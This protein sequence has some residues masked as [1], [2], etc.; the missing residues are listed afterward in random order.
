MSDYDLARHSNRLGAGNRGN[1]GLSGCDG[2]GS[3]AWRTDE[4]TTA[5]WKPPGVPPGIK[6]HLRKPGG[7]RRAGQRAPGR[8]PPNPGTP[9]DPNVILAVLKRKWLTPSGQPNMWRT[10]SLAA[11]AVSLALPVNASSIDLCALRPHEVLPLRMPSAGSRW[12]RRWFRIRSHF[13]AGFEAEM[14]PWLAAPPASNGRPRQIGW[15]IMHTLSRAG[16]PAWRIRDIL[17]ASWMVNSRLTTHKIDP[18]QTDS[19]SRS[20]QRSKRI[21]HMP[22][23]EIG[24]HGIP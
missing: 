20:A 16:L 23:Q 4:P 3:S 9:V 17:R 24:R 5:D 1:G 12:L 13:L 7:R 15:A 14:T 11:L 10:R 8:C 19:Q 21:A 6:P 18:S 22:H 2:S